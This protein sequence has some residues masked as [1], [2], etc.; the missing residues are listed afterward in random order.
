MA[1]HW[2]LDHLSRSSGALGM[3][4]TC[5][6]C[7]WTAMEQKSSRPGRGWGLAAACRLNGAG[8]RHVRDAHPSLKPTDAAD[9]D[10][11]G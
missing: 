4:I 5:K 11:R 9:A 10:G 2:A 3:A 1:R 7:G 6:I 8:I